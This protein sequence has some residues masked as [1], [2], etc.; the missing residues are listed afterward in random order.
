MPILLHA[1]DLHLDSPFS[2]LSPEKAV[3][4]RKE[5]RQLLSRL[6]ELVHRNHV[7]LVLLS[8]DILD[9][10]AVYADTAE[11]LCRALAQMAVPVF[12]APGNHD[13]APVYDG[14]PLPENVT[15]FR[16]E[17]ITSVPL[18]HL[19]CT[20]HGRGLASTAPVP[21]AS[22][23]FSAPQD[24][25]T[26]LLCLHGDV[27]GSILRHGPISEE[28]L[29]ASGVT[30]AALGHIHAY[31]GLRRS[32]S[33]TWAYPGCPEGRGFDETGEKG[34]LLGS[35]E[36]GKVD[37]AFVPVAM[38]RYYDLTVPLTGGVSPEEAVLA[39]LPEHCEDDVVRLTLIGESET[40]DLSALTALCEGRCFSVLLRDR[41]SLPRDLLARAGEDSL[42][43]YFLRTLQA[44][45]GQPEY[46]QALRF[47]LA[48][49][50]NREEP[51]P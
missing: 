41:T 12:L 5:Q 39:A 36:P 30:Y 25:Q 18:P 50:E 1:A 28:A 15:L 40:P 9:G 34:V 45:E 29:A 33:V 2:G 51:C 35:V 37:L 49:L 23:G 42:A 44:Y 13:L 21:F 16:E 24:G 46:E 7:E 43:G 14:I 10:S 4:R 38:R 48:A 20:V 27:N 8:G 47:G 3:Q 11:A 19:H 22:L 31:S 6:T 26:H 17:T 32:G